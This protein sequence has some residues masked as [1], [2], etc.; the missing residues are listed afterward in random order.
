[1]ISVALGMIG[2]GLI[3]YGVVMAVLNMTR[4]K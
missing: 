3:I 4:D 1:M 2:A